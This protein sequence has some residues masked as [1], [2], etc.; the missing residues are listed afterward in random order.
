MGLP[1]VQIKITDGALGG[2]NPTGDGVAGSDNTFVIISR[3]LSLVLYKFIEGGS[4][5]WKIG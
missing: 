1:S 5:L 3:A 4:D 2:F